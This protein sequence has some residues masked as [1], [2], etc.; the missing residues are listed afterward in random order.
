[1]L[2]PRLVDAALELVLAG[3]SGREEPADDRELLG[4]REVRRAHQGDLLVVEV[5]PGPDDRKR[6]DG[7][8]DERRKVRP[9]AERE[10]ELPSLR[11]RGRHDGPRR[12]ARA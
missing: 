7:F 9:G 10:L 2:D 5:G 6:L 11:P 8:A 1:M 3:G 12:P 4:G